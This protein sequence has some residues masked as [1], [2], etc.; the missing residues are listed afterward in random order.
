MRPTQS[1]QS[2][3][4]LLDV[5]DVLAQEK[6]ADAV[7]G[8]MA[9]SVHGAV[10]AS[11]D[12]D[13]I[14]FVNVKRARDLH[15]A[16]NAAGF[17]SS[18]RVGD[19][20]DPIPALLAIEDEYGNR[21]DLLI[22]L[23]GLDRSALGRAIDVPFQGAVLKVLGREDFIA[24]KLFA[25][26]PLDLADADAAMTVD[27]AALDIALLRRLV[28]LFGP[29]ARQNLDSLLGKQRSPPA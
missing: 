6:T 8:A 7:V 11:L 17:T 13:A 10:R 27:Q 9:A 22:G 12:A 21:V 2:A 19:D 15:N 25:G 4:L 5:L 28:E 16:L 24:T 1:G 18:L 26:G 29:E 14:A 23:R 3:L 20:D